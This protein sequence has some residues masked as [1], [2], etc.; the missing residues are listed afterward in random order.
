MPPLGK[1]ISFSLSNHLSGH[2]PVTVLK[3]I[4]RDMVGIVFSFLQ[5]RTKSSLDKQKIRQISQPDSQ[6]QDTITESAG[7]SKHFYVDIDKL[8]VCAK[9]VI[10]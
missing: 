3:M 10:K 4:N 6:T 8:Q 7:S 5:L 2:K 9:R 1:P